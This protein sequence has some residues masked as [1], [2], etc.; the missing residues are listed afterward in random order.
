[1]KEPHVPLLDVSRNFLSDADGVSLVSALF[2]RKAGY[3]ASIKTL[4]MQ[5]NEF[6]DDTA[7][8]LVALFGSEA[9]PAAHG[10]K[11][12]LSRSVLT[13]LNLAYNEITDVGV[14]LIAENI[15][16]RN[17]SNVT[18][19]YLG[20]NKITDEGCIALG[21]ALHTNTTLAVLNLSFN[22]IGVKGAQALQKGVEHND[23]LKV[24]YF[25]DQEPPLPPH[26]EDNLREA[27]KG[28][29][30]AGG[31]EADTDG[32]GGDDAKDAKKSAEPSPRASPTKTAAPLTSDSAAAF[33]Q[34]NVV[35][36]DKR[37]QPPL[38]CVVV[39]KDEL[40][41]MTLRDLRARLQRDLKS[42]L[43]S[44]WV[45]VSSGA[46]VGKAQEGDFMV[47]VVWRNSGEPIVIKKT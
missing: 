9:D 19:L 2:V 6:K 8:Q 40:G 29:R 14:K 43:P 13:C 26:V 7:K 47:L 42:A 17:G 16:A 35:R 20:V 32:G 44:S 36:D 24:L 25:N 18:N 23:A 31:G 22:M 4:H 1:L 21:Q 41:G 10:P 3:R 46:P 37:D 34:L 45:F 12:T 15:L 30:Q 5:G 11:P 27:M 39:K 33:E 38:G 28:E